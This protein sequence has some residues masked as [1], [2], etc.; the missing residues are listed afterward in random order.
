MRGTPFAISIPPQQ[1]GWR[2]F[3]EAVAHWSG[4]HLQDFNVSG[5]QGKNFPTTQA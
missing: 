1:Q 4:E 2:T 5:F 3:R